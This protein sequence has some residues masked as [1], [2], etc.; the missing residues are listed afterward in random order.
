MELKKQSV[1]QNIEKAKEFLQITLDDDYIIKDN[2]PDALKIICSHGMAEIEDKRI[3]GESVWITGKL[4]FSV[5]YRSDDIDKKPEALKAA[6]PFQEKVYVAGIEE[7]DR[8]NVNCKV[9]DLSVGLINSR[10][11]SVRSLLNIEVCVSREEEIEIASEISDDNQME[12]EQL[13]EE[14]D[15][16]CLTVAKKDILRIRKEMQLPKS[17]PNILSMIYDYGDLRNID[18]VEKEDKLLVTGEIHIFILYETEE[19]QCEWYDTMSEF[20]GNLSLG[21]NEDNQ[22]W[23]VN[24]EPAQIQ[25]WAETDFDGEQRQIGMELVFDVQIKGWK[26]QRIPVLAD[27][28]SLKENVLPVYSR[29]KAWSLLMKNIAKC[30]VNEQIHMPAGEEK[31]MQICSCKSQV[32]I[33]RKTPAERGVEVSG[34]INVETLYITS[35]DGFPLVHRTDQLPFSQLI[36]APGIL[37]DCSYELSSSVEMLQVN[38]LDNMEFEIKAVINIMLFA[39]HAE[40]INVIKSINMVDTDGDEEKLPGMTGYIVTEKERLW[41][42]AKKYKTTVK[43]IMEIN[44]LEN[45]EVVP[46]DK[47]M[48]VKSPVRC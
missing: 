2:K 38:L 3:S 24:L 40:E 31:I 12:I 19:G 5:L 47:I 9:E 17:K 26:E 11:M 46:G 33:E 7:S 13:I 43:N 42:I 45:D 4:I 21:G 34:V 27:L 44:D 28:Y 41:D 48:I 1:R 25:L 22:I 35:D 14:K 15:M 23:W 6:I 32:M 18:Y 36:E 10:K 8:I 30:S 29:E 37:E 20:S 39:L 16:L